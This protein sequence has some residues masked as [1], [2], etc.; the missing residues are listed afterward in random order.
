MLI[1]CSVYHLAN[2][3]NIPVAEFKIATR[4]QMNRP[5][6]NSPSDRKSLGYLA[7][8]QQCLNTTTDSKMDLFQF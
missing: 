4:I 2:A 8:V 6:Q 1:I 3:S 5:E 7:L